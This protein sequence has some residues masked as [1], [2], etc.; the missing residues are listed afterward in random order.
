MRQDRR[1]REGLPQSSSPAM[2]L[3]GGQAITSLGRK[4]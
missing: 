4:G 1:H 3:P 2:Q